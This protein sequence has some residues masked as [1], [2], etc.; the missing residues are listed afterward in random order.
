MFSRPELLDSEARSPGGESGFDGLSLPSPSAT[1]QQTPQLADLAA[2]LGPRYRALDSGRFRERLAD[3]GSPEQ[4]F[5]ELLGM[6]SPIAPQPVDPG[7][8]A[9]FEDVQRRLVR[10]GRVSALH[11]C[12][13]S[14]IWPVALV[15]AKSVSDTE[16]TRICQLYVQRT[17]VND[18]FLSACLAPAA[19]SADWRYVLANALLNADAQSL[20]VLERK[21]RTMDVRSGQG[22][23]APFLGARPPPPPPEPQPKEESPPGPKPERKPEPNPEP[24]PE[25]NPEPKAPDPKIGN[26]HKRGWLGTVFG[27]MNPWGGKS[28]VV[29]LSDHD[30]GE[31][32]WNGTRYVV[33]G[34][35]NDSPP[36]PPP[37]LPPRARVVQEAQPQAADNPPRF[38][39]G[40]PP[41]G[42]PPPLPAASPAGVRPATRTRASGRYVN[43]F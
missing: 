37:P 4:Q 24:K 36:P 3:G 26:R 11:F 19:P 7:Q 23:I 20:D 39:M 42:P 9:A 5:F 1:F 28:K 22:I 35:E 12:V 10:D 33:R 29:D 15:L 8:A 13:D 30:T 21:S 25:P 32:V 2:S 43:L 38:E 18:S 27:W 17:F 31:M 6:E 40:A 34:H 14:E 16:F 41:M